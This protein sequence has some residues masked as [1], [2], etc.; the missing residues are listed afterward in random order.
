MKMRRFSKK[1]TEP[2]LCKEAQK[3]V[4]PYIEGE[5]CDHDLRRF[6]R[7]VR[8]CPECREELETYYIVYKGLMQL[9]DKEELPTNILEALKEDLEDSEFYL[10]NVVFFRVLSEIVKLLTAVSCMLLAGRNLMKLIIGV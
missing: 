1:Q 3:M 7:H 2:L 9:D 6:I 5:L 4:V 10:K 8:G